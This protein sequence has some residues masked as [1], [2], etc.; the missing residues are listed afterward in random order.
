MVREIEMSLYR[1]TFDGSYGGKS[2]IEADNI[3]ELEDY[4]ADMIVNGRNVTAVNRVNL[5]GTT[6]RISVLSDSY[7]KNV[8]KKK[9]EAKILELDR[10]LRERDTKKALSYK[11]ITAGLVV[12]VDVDKLEDDE[13]EEKETLLAALGGESNHCTVVNCV[14]DE[15]GEY[16]ELVTEN[17]YEFSIS[18]AEIENGALSRSAK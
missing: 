18:V 10:R 11:D 9:R 5:D 4:I 16:V 1:V 13:L 8:L 3:S 2:F 7:F 6:P 14:C 17:G 15:D 12:N